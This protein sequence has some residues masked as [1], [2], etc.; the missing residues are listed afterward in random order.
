[1][2]KER[3]NKATECGGYTIESTIFL[4]HVETMRCPLEV[5][6]LNESMNRR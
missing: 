5:V 2:G 6:E 1:M 3:G 4:G